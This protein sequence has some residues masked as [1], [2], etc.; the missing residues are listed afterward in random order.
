MEEER[1]LKNSN[2][3]HIYLEEFRWFSNL[4]PVWISINKNYNLN[5]H[6]F[7]VEMRWCIILYPKLKSSFNRYDAV[8]CSVV[9]HRVLPIIT[10]IILTI[11]FPN[12][13][14]SKFPQGTIGKMVFIYNYERENWIKILYIYFFYYLFMNVPF[15]FF[16]GVLQF[17][18][19]SNRTANF[20]GFI[21]TTYI[22]IFKFI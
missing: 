2:Y 3:F 8:H 20:K 21:S 12:F 9:H 18:K 4:F 17:N 13:T 14:R 11:Q 10:E 19:F 6:S 5:F 15:P 1:C 22:K 16:F 7:W